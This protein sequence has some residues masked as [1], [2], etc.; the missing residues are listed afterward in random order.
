MPE[1]PEVEIIKLDLNKL[2]KNKKIKSVKINLAK[3]VKSD[4]NLFIKKVLGSE[5]ISVS[6]RA[7]TLIIELDN[8]YYLVFHLKMTGQLI[9]CGKNGK[10]FWGGHPI[11]NSLIKLPNKYSHVYFE[12]SD[13]SKLF[14]NDIRQFGWVKLLN[15]KELK[16]ENKKYGPE[17]LAKD[18]TV[19][20]FLELFKNK[21]A[22]IKPLI[23]NFGFIA[24]IGNIY[25]QEVLFC[26][27]IRPTH[28]ADKISK[29]EYKKLYKCL[30]KI[31]ITAIDKKGTSSR[32]Y[33]D[34]FGRQGSMNSLFK[35]YGRAGQKCLKCK[36]VLKQ[37]KQAQRSTIYCPK[38]QK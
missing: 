9:Y 13:G 10:I 14:F 38:C 5:V 37:I 2:I 16:Q 24:G 15:G 32:D 27:G 23:M 25:V 30:R 33:V 17:P 1:L 19:E 22:V 34:A 29:S 35:V 36:T 12:F 11:L 28:K 6:R 8:K 20:K 21:K 18:F 26:A 31:L 7:K 4:K 3:Q